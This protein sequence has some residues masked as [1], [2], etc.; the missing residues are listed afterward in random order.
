MANSA[1]GERKYGSK[2][3]IPFNQLPVENVLYSNDGKASIVLGSDRISAPNTGYGGLGFNDSSA[4]DIVCGRGKSISAEDKKNAVVVNPD[5]F[6]DAARIYISEKT[7]VDKNFKLAKGFIG[8]SKS[9]SAVVLKADSVR[10]IGIEGVKIVTRANPTN[11]NGT[12]PGVKGIELIAGNDDSFL[13]PMVKGDNLVKCLSDITDVI[14]DVKAQV[15][16]I[17]GFL[18]DFVDN[19]NQHIHPPNAVSPNAAGVSMLFASENTK[20]S[21]EDNYLSDTISSI[22]SNYLNIPSHDKNILSPYN[23]T[24]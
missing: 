2:R 5:F 4:I 15:H 20:H 24:N 6:S 3:E 7:D 18:E 1:F 12:E 8:D 21:T 22:R 23:K 14:S 10:V 13:Q 9:A 19:Y 17:M 16:S 11:S